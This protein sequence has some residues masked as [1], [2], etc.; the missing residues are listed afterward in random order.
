MVQDDP[1]SAF[2]LLIHRKGVPGRACHV[3]YHGLQPLWVFHPSG[4]PQ[5]D[6]LEICRT[7][8]RHPLYEDG[9][10]AV[11]LLQNDMGG[12]MGRTG[13]RDGDPQ[14]H[15]AGRLGFHSALEVLEQHPRKFALAK[16]FLLIVERFKIQV[17]ER[18]LRQLLHHLCLKVAQCQPFPRKGYDIKGLSERIGFLEAAHKAVEDVH[19]PLPVHCLLLV[20]YL[21]HN[22]SEGA[23][24]MAVRHCIGTVWPFLVHFRPM[25]VAA[26]VAVNRFRELLLPLRLR[27][28]KR[29]PVLFITEVGQEL[30]GACINHKL[31]GLL[32]LFLLTLLLKNL[33]NA[34]ANL[35]TVDRDGVQTQ[36][37]NTGLGPLVVS[38][39]FH[40]HRWR[41]ARHAWVRQRGCRG[42]RGG[43][44]VQGLVW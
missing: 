25:Q 38:P 32:D 16:F 4:Q 19:A 6:I 37:E 33:I 1:H 9:A 42:Q 41:P 39:H 27:L 35:V 36:P 18:F 29:L 12:L 13:V 17:R 40:F 30:H 7:T 15:Q 14:H 5:L 26:E 44:C 24:V 3:Q 21:H 28:G 8:T 2:P 23:K 10:G 31:A 43:P 11:Q 20:A 22:S 34:L